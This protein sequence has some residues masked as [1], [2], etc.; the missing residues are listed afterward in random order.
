M[1]LGA[2]ITSERGK[3]ITKTG[4]DYLEINITDEKCEMITSII[5]ERHGNLYGF[6]YHIGQLASIGVISK[7]KEQLAQE[8]EIELGYSPHHYQ[9]VRKLSSL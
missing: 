4:N 7:T 2:T 3:A 9:D 6:S 5:L 1:K 8:K